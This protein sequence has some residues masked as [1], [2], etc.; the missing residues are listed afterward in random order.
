MDIKP[1]PISQKSLHQSLEELSN[2]IKENGLI[3]PITVRKNTL[4]G[5]ELVAGERR[6]RAA[7]MA[8][9]EI[10]PQWL[11]LVMRWIWQLWQW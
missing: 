6:L 10:Y 11:F 2:S 4:G 8:G 1:N 9:L 7:K 5:Y 3:H